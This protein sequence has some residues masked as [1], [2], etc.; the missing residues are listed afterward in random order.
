VGRWWND[1]DRG[2]W[3]VGEMVLTGECG[4]LWNGTDRGGWGV[5]GLVLTKECG[6]LV[7]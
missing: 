1:T 2:V 7:G 3:G 5:G 4:R 6:V